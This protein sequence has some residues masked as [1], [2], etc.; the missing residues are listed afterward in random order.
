VLV[1]ACVGAGG[2]LAAVNACIPD[3]PADAADAADTPDA[4][5]ADL[6]PAS[7]VCGDG[8]ID[9][10]AG[11]QCDPGPGVGEAGLGGCSAGCRMQCASSAPPWPSNNHCYDLV[12]SV[13]VAQLQKATAACGGSHV[14]TFASEDEFQHV[15]PLVGGSRPFWVGLELTASP[16]TAG[17]YEPGWSP[18]CSGCYAHTQSPDADLPPFPDAGIEGGANSCVTVVALSDPNQSWMEYPC[19]GLSSQQVDVVCELEPVGRLSTPCEAGL[20]ISLVK[21][22]PVKRYVYHGG[23]ATADQARSTCQGIGGR[24]VVLQSHD[25]REQL[26]RELSLLT[27]P[28]QSV[29]IGLTELTPGSNRVPSTWE[30]DDHTP[31]Q[32][33][34]AY[35]SEWASGNPTISQVRTTRA[36]LYHPNTS[37]PP[38]DDTLARN[39]PSLLGTAGLSPFVC[40]I[41]ADTLAA[42]QDAGGD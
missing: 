9:L 11:E 27:V 2:G 37:A 41:T 39:D 19:R 38:V 31:A 32:G 18:S 3:L 16:Y 14:V 21:T 28:L 22:Y 8:I 23:P 36:F 6:P 33:A 13:G 20:C 26:W 1:A 40:E 34:G 29:W 10:Q 30:W 4:A 24:L 15:L 5:E 42:G 25:E 7:G 12:G 35:P 17:F